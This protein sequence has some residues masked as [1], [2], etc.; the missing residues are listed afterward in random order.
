MSTL[1]VKTCD[2]CKREQAKCTLKG[3][4]STLIFKKKGYDL[5]SSCTDGLEEY[6]GHNPFNT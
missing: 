4:W 2:R 5:C 1:T 3:F 6:L